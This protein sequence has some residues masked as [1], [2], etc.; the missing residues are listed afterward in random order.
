[1]CTF[2]LYG[3]PLVTIIIYCYQWL[4][5]DFLEDYIDGWVNESKDEKLSV[6][7]NE[8]K[9]LSDETVEGLHITGILWRLYSSCPLHA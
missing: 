3:N 7:E 1:M 9:Y 2:K 6:T 4:E 8:K 5:K